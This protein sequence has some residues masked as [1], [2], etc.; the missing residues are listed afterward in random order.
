MRVMKVALLSFH[1]AYNYGA[2]LQAYGLQCAVKQLGIDCE[3]INYQNAFRQHAYDMKWQFS[4]AVANKKVI[5]AAKSFVGI[6][7]MAKR[8]KKF[9]EFYSKYLCVSERIYTTSE[10]AKVTNNIYDKFI[11]GSDQVW[12]FSNNGRDA[13]FLLDFV[14]D[15]SKKISYSSSFGVSS[16]PEELQ[17]IYGKYLRSFYRLATRESIGTE[18]VEQMAGRQAHLV[19]DPVFLAGKEEWDKIRTTDSKKRNKYIFFYT[20]RQSQI[21]DFLNTGYASDEDFHVLSTH[22]TLKELLSRRIKSCISMSPEE[23]LSEIYSAKLVVTASFHCLALAI[24]YHK[25]FMVILTGD[26]GK[27]ERITNLLKIAGLENRILKSSTTKTDVL[28]MIDYEQVDSRIRGHLE[29]SREYLRRAIFDET[30]IGIDMSFKNQYFCQDSRCVG[31]GACESV[32]P[33]GAITMGPNEEGF[34]VP[35]LDESKCIH[36]CKCHSVCQIYKKRD[37]VENQHFFA[38][39]NK[40]EIRRI[41]SSGGMFRALAATVFE[42]SGIV[43]AAG[44]TTDFK[45]QHMFA[46]NMNELQPM[47]GTYYVQSII[48]DCYKKIKHYLHE[49]K[50]VLFVGTA[51]QVEGLRDYLGDKPENLYT[52]DIICHGVPSPLVF[53]YFIRFLK[54]KGKLES[55]QFRDK[56]LGW[57]GYHV[58]AIIDGKKVKDKLWIQSYNNMFSHNMINR[59]SCASCAYANYN[60]PGDISIGDFWGIEKNH[61]DIFDK[62]GVSLVIT[63]TEKGIQIL[64]EMKL[65]CVEKVKKEDTKQNSLIKPAGVSSKRLQVFQTLFREDYYITMRKFGEVNIKGAIKDLLRKMKNNY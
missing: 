30:D 15:D 36:C 47:C 16:I 64:K 38:V 21:T 39:K 51:C 29:Y 33:M 7:F 26:H 44:M 35:K 2:A 54:S 6:P 42:H 18:I 46:S 48:S 8:A 28:E 45:V 43:C 57:K 9:E 20:N 53:E 49:G 24:I 13:A 56:S 4:Q 12:N 32:C 10:E 23:F 27:D 1:N 61:S 17:G 19:L 3:Y 41:S 37:E 40:D 11:V 25:Q 34:L 59:L 62:L 63:N 50:I 14:T 22:L 5:S 65:E 55:F 52:C 31:C 60:R 58:S